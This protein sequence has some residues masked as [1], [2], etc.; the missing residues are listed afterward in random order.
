[1]PAELELEPS[2]LPLL[3]VGGAGA[4]VLAIILWREL[5]HR[6]R[7]FGGGDLAAAVMLLAVV[8]ILVAITPDL[9]PFEIAIALL[10]ISLA[11]V[12]RPAQAVKL[13]GGPNARWSALREGRELQLLVRQRGGPIAARADE[14]IATRLEA[15]AGYESPET[16]DYLALV[17]AT[18]LADPAEPGLT[19]QL[20]RLAAADAALRASL[21]ARP[22]WERELERL[23]AEAPQTPPT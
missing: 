7:R 10:V 23:E 21:G 8:G 20:D 1:M 13:T 18:L 2:Q 4:V 19:E 17:S 14:E 3:F 11:A 6:S 12:I 15:L 16:S 5:R 9:L 22:A